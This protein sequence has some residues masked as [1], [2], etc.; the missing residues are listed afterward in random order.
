MTGERVRYSGEPNRFSAK[1]GAT[2]LTARY[3]FTRSVYEKPRRGGTPAQ[4]VSSALSN[5]SGDSDRSLSATLPPKEWATSR[6]LPTPSAAR[7]ARACSAYSPTD[8]G[9]VSGSLFPM[10]GKSKAVTRKNFEKYVSW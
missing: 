1:R 2:F 8:H 5:K 10:P 7:T 6:A 3:A 9:E 4:P